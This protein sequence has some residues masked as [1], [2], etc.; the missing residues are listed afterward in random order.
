MSSAQ[1][2]IRA[3]SCPHLRNHLVELH[4]GNDWESGGCT[5]VGLT[6]PVRRQRSICNSFWR[7]RKVPAD[8]R[9]TRESTINPISHQ[10]Q[11]RETDGGEVRRWAKGASLLLSLSS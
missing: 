9:K 5:A 1:L 8:G 4:C 6:R 3:V 10:P 2:V 7:R 11:V